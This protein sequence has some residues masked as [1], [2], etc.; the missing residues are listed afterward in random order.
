MRRT[1][2]SGGRGNVVNLIDGGD[3]VLAGVVRI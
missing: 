1:A 3:L 2:S